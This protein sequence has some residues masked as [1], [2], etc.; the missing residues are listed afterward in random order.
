MKG[1]EMSK[2]YIVEV[3]VS[4]KILVEISDDEDEHDAK[5][6][7]IGESRLF[8]QQTELEVQVDVE[9]VPDAPE[10]LER[11]MRCAHRVIPRWGGDQGTGGE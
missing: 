11:K 1:K 4:E 8:R 3:V 6:I 2:W 5:E 7:A 10:C 9:P